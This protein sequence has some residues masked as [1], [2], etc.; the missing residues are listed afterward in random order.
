MSQFQFL[1]IEWGDIASAAKRAEAQVHADP[2]AACFY[3]RRALELGVNWLYR[4]DERLK[5]PYQDH[6]SALLH[7]PS[8]VRAVGPVV[9]PKLKLIKDL[10]NLAVHSNKP[11]SSRDAV[12]AVR[13]LFHFGYW[14]ARTYGQ[15]TRPDV[16]LRFDS[17]A[18]PR[19]VPAAPSQADALLRLGEELAAKDTKLSELLSGRV[20]LDEELARLRAEVAA[21]RAANTATPDTH[22]YNEAETRDVFI[23]VLLK[24][25]GWALDQA[26]DREF[27]VVGMPNAKGEGFVDYVLWGDDGKPL[28]LVEAKRTRRDPREGQQQAKLYADCLEAMTGQRPVIF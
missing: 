5:L 21:A 19:P 18:L 10:G 4:T 26:R 22:D 3:C 8:F 1:A 16:G 20:A 23:D 14:L 15:R 6:L 7:E 17:D 12:A 24:E 9:L 13:E 28:A 2:R 27:P 25:A 11:I